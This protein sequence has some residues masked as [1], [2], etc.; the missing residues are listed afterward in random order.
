ME[1]AESYFYGGRYA[2]AIK[3]YD[4]VLQIEPRWERARQHRGE[5]ENY[6]RTGHIPSVALPPE[7]ASSFGKA[8]SAARLGRYADAL[9]MLNKAQSA[10]R[11]LGIQRWQDGQEFEQKLQQ[12]IDAESVYSEGVQL[13]SQGMIDDAIERVDAAAQAT[14]LPRYI[15]RV[16]E[17][18]KARSAMQ[19][20]AEGLTSATRRPE[21][22]RPGQNRPG[23]PVP[24]IRREPGFPQAQ[25]ALP[26]PHPGRD[27]AAQRPGARPQDP[28]RPVADA[29]RGGGQGPPGQGTARPGAQP[30]LLGRVD[31]ATAG[32]DR[33]TG[34]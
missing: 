15:D 14:G 10:L 3:L 17:M 20:I 31:P 2:E 29:G 18:R 4:A 5:S 26:D 28:G 13:F 11:D 33:E 30:G 23:R 19:S 22:Y 27:R 8:Q 7:A 6:L 9:A 21:E 1:E 16:Q 12:Y 34:A 24:A 32:R 25:G